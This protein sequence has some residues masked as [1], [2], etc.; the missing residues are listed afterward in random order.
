VVGEGKAVDTAVLRMILRCATV[1]DLVTDTIG[2]R[3]ALL[4]G[5]ATEN[6]LP[7]KRTR[8]RTVVRSRQGCNNPLDERKLNQD[9]HKERA[10]WALHRTLL[11][12]D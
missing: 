1:A 9:D 5:N 8:T 10:V 12:W 3:F 11:N 4:E 6:G 2:L 7:A